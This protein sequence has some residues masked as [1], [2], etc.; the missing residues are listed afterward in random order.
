[1]ELLAALASGHDQ[2]GLFELPQM[3]HD[4]EPCDLETTFERAE[5]LPVLSEQ[6]RRAGSGQ[7]DLPAP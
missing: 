2:A 3:L 7:S 1:M 5:C 4:P 6:L